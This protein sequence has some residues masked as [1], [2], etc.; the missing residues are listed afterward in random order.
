MLRLCGK[1][2]GPFIPAGGPLRPLGLQGL[3]AQGSMQLARR[4]T[5][6][7]LDASTTP[8]PSSVPQGGISDTL[9]RG[10]KGARSCSQDSHVCG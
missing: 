1:H 5:T 10:M 4:I 7:P 8:P 9:Q 2:L 6:P 3:S